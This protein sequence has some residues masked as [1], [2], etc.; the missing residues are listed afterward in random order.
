M[1]YQN[2]LNQSSHCTVFRL[3]Y[4]YEYIEPWWYPIFL[5]S[6]LRQRWKSFQLGF[7]IILNNIFFLIENH[8]PLQKNAVV[9]NN[10]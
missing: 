4:S 8:K 2:V 6:N 5:T 10:K 1:T 3:K 7:N 9:N